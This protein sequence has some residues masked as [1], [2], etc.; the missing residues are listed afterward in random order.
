VVAACVFTA[1]LI[2]SQRIPPS[3]DQAIIALM[4]RFIARGSGHPVFCWGSTYGGTLEP[5][6]LA[7]AFAL[8][9]DTMRVFRAVMVVFYAVF[10]VGVV[11]LAAR[12]FGRPA[13]IVA[14]VY[15]AFP[16]FFLPYKLLTS[17]G[18]YAS[19]AI[20]ALSAVW[21]CLSADEALSRGR[22]VT[23]HMA[24]LG[25]V[26]GLGLWV[27]PV[28]LPVAA[29]AFLW[30]W[31]QRSGTSRFASLLAWGAGIAAG[32][33]PWWIWNVRHGWAS[34][35][36]REV[37]AATGGG[38]FTNLSAFLSASLPVLL[39]AA[40]TNFLDDPHASFRGALILMPFLVVLLLVPAA[41]VAGS[42]KRIR[43]LLLA[44]GAQSA[45]TVLA[46]RFSPSE[47]RYLVAAYVLLPVLFGV[48]LER[49]PRGLLRTLWLGGFAI[50]IAG[51]V[52][53]SL[54]ARRHLEDRDDS[55]VT[56]P[57]EPLIDA[58]REI[59]ATH[60]WANYAT[61]YRVT[62]ESGNDIIAT[63]ILREDGV[64]DARADDAVRSAPNPAIVLLPPRDACFRA[65]L[66]EEGLSSRERHAGF[67]AIFH[68]LPEA[69]RDQVRSAGT[70]PMPRDAY[71]VSWSRP[72]VPASAAPG[73]RL[74]GRIR[75]TNEGPC[76]WMNSVGLLAI[77]SGPTAREERVPTPGRRVA[78]AES[79]DL[80]FTLVAPRSPGSY[81]LRLDL[82]QYGTATFS[83][84]GAPAFTREI[85]VR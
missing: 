58:L 17:D 8:F 29:V 77:W 59:R 70:L 18:A 76:T 79:A 15:L 67:F 34:L 84:R 83:S 57:L 33:A 46:A 68:G 72:D 23:G 63:P 60:V 26:A 66:A 55:Q 73:S 65:F 36:A 42:D 69:L 10:A 11:G 47:P 44:L 48:A 12:F 62:F 35:R 80:V 52:S 53:N 2:V 45:A 64:R 75:V 22:E 56:G 74:A 19:V 38:L 61:A 32:S 21:I 39:G 3:G 16:P 4:A 13:A 28:T 31:I 5:H 85:S 81:E 82:E 49:L 43:L 6:V 1:W 51:D 40:R 71:R 78:P 25:F 50:L 24:G 54:H 37:A 7:A 20:L 14:A 30:L 27:S 9:G 41:V